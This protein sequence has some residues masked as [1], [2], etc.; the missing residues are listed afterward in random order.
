MGLLLAVC[1]S[2][3]AESAQQI[4]DAEIIALE[5]LFKDGFGS[6]SRSGGA[7]RRAFKNA[8]RTGLAIAEDYPEAPNRFRVLGIVV[9]CQKRMFTISGTDK[10]REALF[11]TC[12]KLVEA[13]D[14]YAK[15]RLEADLLLSDRDLSARD[16]T[17]EERAQAL[18][19]LLARYEGTAA[20]ARS[21]L[22]GALIVQKLESRELEGQ[23]LYALDEK[24]ADDHEVIE[25]R[26]KFLKFSRLDLVFS[27]SHKRIDGTQLVFPADTMGHMSL[28]IFWSKDKHGI[29]EYLE[30]IKAAITNAAGLIDVFSFNLDELPDGGASVLAGHELDWTVM[31]LPGGR[32]SQAYQSYA[33][34]DPVAILVNEYGIA[35]TRPEIVH[36]RA[37]S[38]D[39]SRISDDR[40]MAQ[41]QSLFI[42]DVLVTASSSLSQSTRVPGHPNTHGTAEF[43]PASNPESRVSDQATQLRALQNCFVAPP[44]RYRLTREE[45][46]SNYKKAVDLCDKLMQASPAPFDMRRVRDSKIIA[47]L[48]M[49]NLACEPVHLKAAVREAKL[50]IEVKLPPE[51]QV[52]SRFC[53][54]KEALRAGSEKPE[55]VVSEFLEDCGGDEAPAGALAA[56]SVLAIEAK[57]REMYD[58]YRERFLEEHADNPQFYAF[59]SFLRD[60]HIQYRI[61]KANHTLR[62]RRARGYI[63]GHG[64]PWPTNYLPDMVFKNLDGSKLSMP[65][66]TNGKLTY[67]MFVEPPAGGGT[68]DFPFDI[69]RN[70]KPTRNDGIRTVMGYAND[71]TK[72]HVN[73][74]INFVAAF[75]T[76]D[77]EHVKY[78]VQT[79]GWECQAVMVPGGLQNPM[80]RRLGI[81]SA[82]RFPNVFVLR[83]DGSIAWHGSGLRYKNEF[84]YPFAVLL[85]MKVHVEVCEIETAYTALEKGDYKEAA[86]V[87]SGPFPEE[88]PQ[89]FAWRSP[90]Y[91]GQ[92]IAYVGMKEWEAALES[93]DKAID[94]HK[95]RHFHG[96]GRRS[97]HLT[98]WR[99]D[100]ALVTMK[101]PCDTI[102]MLWTEKAAILDKLGRSDEAEN[103]RKLGEKPVQEHY[104]SVYETFHQK[105]D[106]L[107]LIGK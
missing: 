88:R 86:R 6:N 25:F 61:L 12:E 15:E 92:T 33:Q 38:V 84:G 58:E 98:D 40:Y 20:E 55:L 72:K 9:E 41:L 28:I 64:Y 59:T 1:V 73:G 19:E 54:A 2:G 81:L 49:W 53:L 78:L 18:A 76:D 83:R 10:N 104:N 42:G 5:Q 74:D 95:L 30:S 22:M 48:G 89:R 35:V 96:Y 47:L 56:A 65:K 60:R 21:L 103:L 97:K 87:F 105:L 3:V 90:R 107:N 44:F 50:T 16:A 45:A 34:G 70:N 106:D 31:K 51:A 43:D 62:E 7:S 99:K 71:L 100:A 66:D 8:A 79:N 26:R 82:D 13:P 63:V 94:A 52:V 11:K 36:G 91:H 32:R 101:E 57:S 85:A 77:A 39:G 4:P 29:D 102:C 14:E 93:I 68:N 23:I 67:L 80:I 27:G 37:A 69:D 24:F 75:L 46:L 17:L